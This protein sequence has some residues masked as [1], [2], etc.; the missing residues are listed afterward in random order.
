MLVVVVFLV[1]LA[2]LNIRGIKESLGANVVATSIEL[3][4]LLLIIGLGGWVMLRG[5]ADPGRLVQV[6]TSDQG[7]ARAVLAGTV[8]AFYSFVGF[9]TSVNL[10]E[11]VKTRGVRIPR[12]CSA[13]CSPQVWCTR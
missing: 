11:E 8:L 4:G 5:D 9:E 12:R 1:E 2:A 6:G 13:R 7:A 10:A 3:S